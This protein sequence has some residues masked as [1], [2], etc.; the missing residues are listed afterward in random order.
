MAIYEYRCKVCGHE[1]TRSESLQEHGSTR[2]SCPE[3]RSAKVERVFTGF[4]AKTV[5]KS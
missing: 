3:C 1:F 4:Y 2:V 5:R